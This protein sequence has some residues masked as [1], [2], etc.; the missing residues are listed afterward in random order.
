MACMVLRVPGGVL[1]RLLL[2]LSV[3]MTAQGGKAMARRPFAMFP[4][5]RGDGLF[6]VVRVIGQTSFGLAVLLLRD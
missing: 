4:E 5:Q 6:H 2:S 3:L 1:G